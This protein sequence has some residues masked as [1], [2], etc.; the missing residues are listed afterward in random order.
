MIVWRIAGLLQLPVEG[1]R[2]VDTGGKTK[3]GV[4]VNIYY[5]MMIWRHDATA[6]WLYDEDSPTNV[7]LLQDFKISPCAE[8]LIILPKGFDYQ[9]KV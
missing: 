7:L 1:R 3:T 6:I 9:N 8:N 5:K 2:L 4:G